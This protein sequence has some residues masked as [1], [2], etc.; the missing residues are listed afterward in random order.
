MFTKKASTP[1]LDKSKEIRHA[2]EKAKAF[3]FFVFLYRESKKEGF[4]FLL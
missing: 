1:N 4:L 3:W 2:K